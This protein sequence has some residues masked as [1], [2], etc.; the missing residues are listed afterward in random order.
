ML[1]VG[2]RFKE[3]LI[4]VCMILIMKFQSLCHLVSHGWQIPEAKDE[5][6]DE[7]IFKLEEEEGKTVFGLQSLQ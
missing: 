2:K 1:L 6:M 4:S 3:D 5:K 7:G